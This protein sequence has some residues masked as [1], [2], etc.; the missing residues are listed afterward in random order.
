LN[1]NITP[2]LIVTGRNGLEDRIAG[3]RAGADDYLTKPL[4]MDELIARLHALLRRPGRRRDQLLAAGNVSL[5]TENHQV[6]VGDQ[7]QLF[8][9]REATVLELLLRD[10]DR[11]V[12]RR[13]FEDHLYGLSG[14]QDSNAI[15]VSV[16]R[17]RKQLTEAEAT[18]QI[19]TIRGVGYMLSEDKNA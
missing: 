11:V 3:L 18:V 7:R 13:M 19:H 12:P 6:I 2:V 15:D 16:H 1:G 17:L 8:R 5:D 10:K 9:L 14:E 4:V